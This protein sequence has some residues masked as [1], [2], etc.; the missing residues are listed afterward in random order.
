[1]FQSKFFEVWH[2]LCNWKLHLPVRTHAVKS[3]EQHNNILLVKVKGE[4]VHRGRRM[5]EVFNL[6]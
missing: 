6:K 3:I 4:S 5:K 2:V 1:M